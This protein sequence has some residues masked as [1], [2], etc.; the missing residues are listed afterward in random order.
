MSADELRKAIDVSSLRERIAGSDRS[1]A[2]NFDEMVLGSGVDRAWEEL[3][4]Q[5]EPEAM[6]R[7]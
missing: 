3:R 4:G 2:A 6:P 5:F 7:E 1:V